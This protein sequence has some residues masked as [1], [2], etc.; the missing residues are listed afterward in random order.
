[1]ISNNTVGYKSI[2]KNN[3][4]TDDPVLFTYT[5]YYVVNKFEVFAIFGA[6]KCRY[7]FTKFT[8]F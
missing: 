6:Q 1:M 2:T 4:T 7:Y 8:D 5:I 3:Q